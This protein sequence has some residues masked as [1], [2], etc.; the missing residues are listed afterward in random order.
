[1]YLYNKYLELCL[2]LCSLDIVTV[3][4]SSLKL[5]ISLTVGFG[6]DYG[7]IYRFHFVNWKLNPLR[8]YV[9]NVILLM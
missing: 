1:M 4:G 2:I 3:V 6:P 7:A 8:K 5:L 9:A